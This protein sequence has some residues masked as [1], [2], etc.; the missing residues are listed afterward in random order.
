MQ[1]IQHAK[2]RCKK[3]MAHGPS[4]SRLCSRLQDHCTRGVHSPV[5]I[6]MA[7][8]EPMAMSAENALILATYHRVGVV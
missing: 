4:Q 1:H 3:E 6:G 7:S 5:S 2:R 8:Y